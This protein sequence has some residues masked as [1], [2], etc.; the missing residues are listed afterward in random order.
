[1]LLPNPKLLTYSFTFT[2]ISTLHCPQEEGQIVISFN[3]HKLSLLV[4]KSAAASCDVCA[5]LTICLEEV[6]ERDLSI[7]FLVL[8]LSLIIAA[9]G[10]HSLHICRLP[11]NIMYSDPKDANTIQGISVWFCYYLLSDLVDVQITSN[12]NDNLFAVTWIAR[13]RRSVIR[14]INFVII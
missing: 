13:L 14:L 3:N 6:I 7:H 4:P 1:M 12:Y 9:S 10:W 8:S 5:F 2:S 11:F